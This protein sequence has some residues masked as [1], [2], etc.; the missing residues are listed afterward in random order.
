MRFFL[1][2]MNWLLRDLTTEDLA[3]HVAA[4]GRANDKGN[5]RRVWFAKS[6]DEPRVRPMPAERIYVRCDGELIG[7]H[8]CVGT[9]R[10]FGTDMK[11]ICW[12]VLMQPDMIRLE[13]PIPAPAQRGFI[14]YNPPSA[15]S[16]RP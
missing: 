10:A 13:T 15:P 4:C 3:K 12:Q 16:V 6:Y 1:P 14:Q 11:F 8:R 7:Y 5:L 9:N 2:T